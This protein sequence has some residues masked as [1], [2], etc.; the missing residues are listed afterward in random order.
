MSDCV[1]KCENIWYNISIIKHIEYDIGGL[2]MIIFN[3]GMD[4]EASRHSALTLKKFTIAD[5]VNFGDNIDVHF[6]FDNGKI[7]V[8][9]NPAEETSPEPALT[10]VLNEIGVFG[11]KAQVKTKAEVIFFDGGMLFDLIEGAIIIK[12]D[13][14]KLM[15]ATKGIDVDALPTVHTEEIQWVSADKLMQYCIYQLKSTGRNFYPYDFLFTVEIG[16]QGGQGN[17]FVFKPVSDPVDISNGAVELKLQERALHEEAKEIK[18]KMRV[19]AAP[20]AIPAESDDDMFN[21]FGDAPEYD[22]S[23]DYSDYDDDDDEF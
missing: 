13:S 8:T 11:L 12:D 4:R 21:D 18:K 3:K 19:F 16:G 2:N 1:D 5:D 6:D 10:F 20:A 17:D 23:D 15:T 22:S 9:K 14:G 7:V